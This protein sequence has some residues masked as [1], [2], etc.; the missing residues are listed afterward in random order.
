MTTLRLAP[1]LS[2]SAR[3]MPAVRF[4][5]FTVSLDPADWSYWIDFH[6]DAAGVAEIH[7]TDFHPVSFE[8]DPDALVRD[9]MG[10]LLTF[11]DA[12]AEAIE[13]QQREGRSSENADLFPERL[14][15]WALA[16]HDEIVGAAWELNEEA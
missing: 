12:Y 6:G 16:E 11:L 15:E 1:P 7:G 3:L 4:D 5:N 9:V 8:T 13:Y 10:S 14:A 2:I